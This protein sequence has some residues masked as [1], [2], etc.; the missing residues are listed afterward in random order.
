MGWGQALRALTRR[1]YVLLIGLVVTSALAYLAWMTTPPTYSAQGTELL[2]PPSAQVETGTKNPLLELSG[3]DAPAALVIGRLDGQAVREEVTAFSAEA[4]YT[5]ET[6][7]TLRGPTVLV[8][9]TDVSPE[10][11][12][13]SL[14][15]V[16]DMV[17]DVLASLQSGLEVPPAATVT[18][19]R[20]ATDS[21]PEPERSATLRALVLAAG[22]GLAVTIIAAVAL[23]AWLRR[24]GRRTSPAGPPPSPTVAGG[25]DGAAP[26]EDAAAPGRDRDGRRPSTDQD[27]DSDSDTDEL[28]SQRS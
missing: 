14:E 20:L 21:E 22:I 9:M 5:V 11:A 15:Y 18:S 27:E 23:D 2:L 3:L 4:D 10:K 7:P 1:W 13:E 6:D 24:R 26:D 19:M 17:P 25:G 12:L 28:L 16:L 8:T